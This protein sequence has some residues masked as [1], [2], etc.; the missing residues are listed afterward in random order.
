[1]NPLERVAGWVEDPVP[2][3]PGAAAATANARVWEFDVEAFIHRHNLKIRR[4]GEWKGGLKWE[5]EFCPINPQHTGGCAV[6]TKAPNG[7]LGY[8]CQ[9]NS[10]AGI[11]WIE[12]RQQL[13]P[14][15]RRSGHGL[16]G[17]EPSAG[18]DWPPVVPFSTLPVDRVLED[19][20]PGAVGDMARAVA[21]ATETPIEMALM[22]GLGIVAASVAGKVQICPSPGHMEP[23]QIYVATV[24][25][26]GNRK[27]AVIN[28]MAAPFRKAEA[29]LIEL[30][31]PERKR[32][33]SLR[34]T[35]ELAI[36]KLRKQ[37]AGKRE[38]GVLIA[39][40]ADREVQLPDVPVVPQL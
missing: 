21:A 24:L 32:L 22:T 33:Q 8:K 4:R 31:M 23:L 25:P 20:L 3:D 5:L 6:I 34:K 37:A 28:Q 36:G 10:C 35:E 13:E 40:I 15:C 19:L 1:M 29:Q 38:A 26:S 16:A 30:I 2:P 18:E 11:G 14:D 27:T 39:E 7:A 9:H 17:V 12:L